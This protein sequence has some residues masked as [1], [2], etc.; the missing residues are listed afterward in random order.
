MPVVLR[1]RAAA[2]GGSSWHS[3]CPITPRRL[4]D[5]PPPE[6]A[7]K[8]G[9]GRQP[10]PLSAS[11]ATPRR[12]AFGTP[13]PRAATCPVPSPHGSAGPEGARWGPLQK[14][15]RRSLT[16]RRLLPSAPPGHSTFLGHEST[17]FAAWA[18][19]AGTGRDRRG[20]CSR[21]RRRRHGRICACATSRAG[22]RGALHAARGNGRERELAP[23]PLL[24]RGR[25][26]RRRVA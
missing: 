26:C 23:A 15:L 14:A 8:L 22:S 13:H 6:T 21:G 19:L 12:S 17:G 25:P 2:P 20:T 1:S 5:S 11:S 9:R 3:L 10:G 16:C 24:R 7:G 18:P 4:G